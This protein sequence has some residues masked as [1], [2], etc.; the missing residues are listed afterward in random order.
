MMRQ[1]LR[2]SDNLSNNGCHFENQ[3]LEGGQDPTAPTHADQG[4]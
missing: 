2:K 4:P 3:H 1:S